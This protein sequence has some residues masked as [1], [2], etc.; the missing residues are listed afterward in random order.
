MKRQIEKFTESW[1]NSWGEVIE[2]RTIEVGKTY[3]ISTHNREDGPELSFT[4][5]IVRMTKGWDSAP[6]DFPEGSTPAEGSDLDLKVTFENGVL[7]EEI[8]E[9][10]IEEVQ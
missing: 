6:E 5:K 7:M 10:T 3:K 8:M 1:V 9:V 4:S 2:E